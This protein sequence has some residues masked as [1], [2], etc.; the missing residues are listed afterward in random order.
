[1]SSGHR[2]GGGGRG[3][4][5]WRLLAV[6]GVLVAI[7]AVVGAVLAVVNHPETTGL[8]GPTPGTTPPAS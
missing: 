8:G 3:R 6:A 1:V 2:L 7:V 4:R 5:R